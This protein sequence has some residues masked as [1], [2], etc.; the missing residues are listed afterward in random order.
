MHFFRRTKG[1]SSTEE[2]PPDWQSAE[3]PKEEVAQKD[4][5]KAGNFL[6][7]ILN[8]TKKA[9]EDTPSTSQNVWKSF[10]L[11]ESQICSF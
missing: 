1:Y 3:Q 10:N 7:V 5:R 4:I 9:K 8:V 6:N 2:E 11:V